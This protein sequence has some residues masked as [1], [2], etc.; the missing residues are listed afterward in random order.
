MAV[1]VPI[2]K[3]ITE[4]EEKIMFGL[5]GRKLICFG[6]AIVLSI[7]T[8]FLSTKVFGISMDNTGYIIIVEVIPL[9]ALGFIKKDGMP[10][11][12]YAALVIRHKTGARK[13]AYE[14]KI[15][16]DAIGEERNSKY[17]WIF[18]KNTGDGKKQKGT[19]GEAN[20][21]KVTKKDRKRKRKAAC[22]EIKRARQ[23]YRTA[24]RQAK[25]ETKEA[26][27]AQKHTRLNKI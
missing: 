6:L 21:F 5:S 1:S 17:D 4:Y 16:M 12:K 20:L 15:L 2:L 26:G 13:L 25:K 24:K 22:R 14:N 7:G 11:E 23:E 8:Y 19:T 27:S 9:L 3:E 18:E 10:F